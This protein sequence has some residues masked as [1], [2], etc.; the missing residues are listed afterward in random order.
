MFI[1]G[2]IGGREVGIPLSNVALVSY[3]GWEEEDP[4]ITKVGVI[5]NYIPPRLDIRLF[6]GEII[7]FEAEEAER[8]WK[9]QVAAYG[10]DIQKI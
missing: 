7:T 5:K 9:N 6:N 1:R 3:K 10:L 8:I 4:R 2:R